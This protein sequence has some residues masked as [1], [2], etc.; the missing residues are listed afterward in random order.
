MRDP[1]RAFAL[2]MSRPAPTT[3]QSSKT[4]HASSFLSVCPYCGERETIR[5]TC[6]DPDCQRLRINE[7]LKEYNRNRDA[8][9]PRR[10]RHP[11][12]ST[13]WDAEHRE[14]RLAASRERHAI[15]RQRADRPCR[16][17]CGGLAMIGYGECRP[18]RRLNRP[19]NRLELADRQAWLCLW[20][21]QPLPGDVGS[22]LV[23][24]DHIIPRAVLRIEEQW[25]FQLLHRI[26]NLRKRDK[27][28]PK[29]WALAAEHG[30]Q[31]LISVDGSQK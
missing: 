27:M 29:A 25:N 6:G 20:C 13:A 30:L 11:N 3:V 17:R 4:E 26:C 14:E 9:M 23:Q 31:T 18:C 12:M 19:V 24:V 7:R 28:T 21:L 15:E 10:Q 1:L 5:V 8:E 16:Y 2:S 22:D